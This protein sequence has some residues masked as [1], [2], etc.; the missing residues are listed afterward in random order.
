[1]R[2]VPTLLS[3]PKPHHL[4]SHSLGAKAKDGGLEGKQQHIT[5]TA[6]MC[7]FVY[8]SEHVNPSIGTAAFT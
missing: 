6:C 7:A 8:I 2:N 3:A 1:M 4:A 5:C